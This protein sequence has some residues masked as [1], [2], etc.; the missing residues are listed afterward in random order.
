MSYHLA[1]DLAANDTVAW[2]ST[3]GADVAELTRLA[4]EA[5]KTTLK[6]ALG[7]GR[8]SAEYAAAAAAQVAADAALSLA[9]ARVD[10]TVSLI[11]VDA[12]LKVDSEYLTVRFVGRDQV[13]VGRAAFGSA[14]SAH[15]AGAVVYQADLRV[16][17]TFDIEV[18]VDGDG[19]A[20][21]A[22]DKADIVAPFAGRISAVKLVADQAG[23]LVVDI[24]RA[25]FNVV[26]T[27]SIVGAT[28]PFLSASR[29]YSDST[30][31][32]WDTACDADDVLRV[33]VVSASVVT[34]VTVV[35]TYT[36]TT[37]A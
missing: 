1:R 11:P 2:L 3:P 7:K 9:Q 22:G 19:V 4:R 32:A 25:S 20:I 33:L 17:A 12:V 27:V 24:L 8:A 16:E 23:D 15:S 34:R 6:T 37:A 30:L 13:E 18:V 10:A 29:T 28:L 21:V 31:T 36:T 26:P 14:R 35:V 5:D